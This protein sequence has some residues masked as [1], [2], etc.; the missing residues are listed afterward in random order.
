MKRNNI[1]QITL[2]NLVASGLLTV[3]AAGQTSPQH[4]VSA[5]VTARLVLHISIK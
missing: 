2:I 1:W 3:S 5:A 4:P